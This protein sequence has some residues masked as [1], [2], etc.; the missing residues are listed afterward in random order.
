MSPLYASSAE[1][2][3]LSASSSLIRRESSQLG[4]DR[5]TPTDDIPTTLAAA[6]IVP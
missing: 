4:G 6:G 5:S 3:I 1:G 2:S